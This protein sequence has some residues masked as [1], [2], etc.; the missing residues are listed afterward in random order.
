M[1]IILICNY[2][3]KGKTVTRNRLFLAGFSFLYFEHKTSFLM[4]T[5]ILGFLVLLCWMLFCRWHYVC[6]V[7][8]LCGYDKQQVEQVDL[9]DKSLNFVDDGKAILK[10]YDQFSF[11]EGSFQPNLN[12]NNKEFINGVADYLKKNPGKKVTITGNYLP[13]EVDTTGN[14]AYGMFEN[15]GL[16]RADA[17]RKMLVA[18]G[19][20]EKRMN[21]DDNLLK[22]GSS[23]D[24]PLSFIGFGDAQLADGNDAEGDENEKGNGKNGEE[25]PE[26]YSNVGQ[27]FSFTNMS[28]SDANFA[29]NSAKFEPGAAFR[30][31]ADSVK[32]YMT[33]N[34]GK[35]LR[36][37]GHTC[38]LGSD[39]YNKNLG[40]KR[41]ESVRKYFKNLGVET[42][43]AT[44]S[45]GE[46]KPAYKNDSNWARSKNRRVVVQIK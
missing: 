22:E 37:V 9:R 24:K 8:N 6:K 25:A 45:E 5:V 29:Y 26:E 12:D 27:E 35:A 42:K 7:Q 14:T 44:Y 36:L 43:I 4:R 13:S 20:D 28:F 15:I 16:A 23:L 18:A 38:D 10:G 11:K 46:K 17:I 34:E 2:H 33:S 30:N 31:Y 21:L 32:I 39:S 40:Q 41:A 19:V 3:F 1:R